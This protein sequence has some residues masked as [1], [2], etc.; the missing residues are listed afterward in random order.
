MSAPR[1][2]PNSLD[3]S[4]WSATNRIVT[5]DTFIATFAP[6]DWLIDG[7]IQKGRLYAC[8][9]LTGH[10]KTAVWLYFAC[11]VQ[12]GRRAGHLDTV[13][14]NV[15]YLAGENPEDLKA[16]MLGM[17]QQFSLPSL[18]LPYVLP[19][20]FPLNDDEADSL[21]HDIEALGVP[22][23]LII[24]DTAASFFPGEDENDNVAS[25]RYARTLRSLAAVDGNPA[26]TVL[27][28][29]TKHAAR[30]NLLPRGGSAFLNELDGNLTLWSAT[31]GEVTTLHWHGKIRGPDFSPLHFKLQTIWTGHDDAKGRPFNTIIARPMDEEE[32]A[33]HNKQGLANEDVVLKA[34]ADQP[35]ISMAATARIIGWLDSDGEPERWK[36]QRALD[37]LARD[38]MV[39]QERARGPWTLTDKGKKAVNGAADEV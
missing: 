34:M 10:G 31:M 12:A 11:M 5:G 37:S 39:R 7:I 28:H 19:R 33:D 26:V 21:K 13:K 6:P 27:S 30:D 17:C 38:K 1:S 9:S 24:G 36:V 15:L 29:P 16:R 20:T 32:A 22:L 4:Y 35:G 23:T 25:G 14:G 8:T 2:D 18:Q 3:D